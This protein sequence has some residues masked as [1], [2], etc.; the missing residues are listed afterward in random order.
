MLATGVILLPPVLLI[1]K[2][3]TIRNKM[4]IQEITSQ[5][6]KWLVDNGYKVN[7]NNIITKGGRQILPDGLSTFVMTTIQDVNLVAALSNYDIT[8]IYTQITSIFSNSVEKLGI[9]SEKIEILNILK[10]IP[11]RTPILPI[12]LKNFFKDSAVYCLDE[13]GTMITLRRHGTIGNQWAIVNDLK[14]GIK[15][16]PEDKLKTFKKI[17]TNTYQKPMQG[18]T[19]IVYNSDGSEYGKCEWPKLIDIA[20]LRAGKYCKLHPNNKLPSDDY[21]KNIRTARTLSKDVDPT[22][23]PSYSVTCDSIGN[24]NVIYDLW[25]SD[26]ELAVDMPKTLTNDPN[27]PA[28]CYVDINTFKKAETPEFDGF[29]TS[30][31][32][33]VREVFMA[34][35]YATVFEPCHHSLVVWMHGEGSNGKSEFFSAI[36]EY[37]GGTLVGSMSTK[38]LS[39]EFGMEGLIGKRIIIWGDCQNGN[40]LSTNEVHGITGGDSISVNRKNKPIISYKFKSLLFIGAN[41]SPDIKLNAINETRRVLYVPMSDPSLEVMQ[42]YCETNIDGTIKRHSTGQPMFKS[43]DLRGKLVIEM[44]A[45]MG[46][47]KEM[48]HKYCK[49]P[50]NQI[51]VPPEAFELMTKQ[52]EGGQNLVFN[53]FMLTQFTVTGNPKDTISAIDVNSAY[54]EHVHGVQASKKLTQFNFELSDLKRYILTTHK[55]DVE[56]T[57]ISVGNQKLRVYTGLKRGVNIIKNDNE[58]TTFGGD[59]DD[60]L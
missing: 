21:I 60:F 52:C 18:Q 23:I 31:A 58:I 17:H 29:L 30:I 16:L 59:S 20:V 24:G 54:L 12:D 53:D 33:E 38:T 51:T 39:G 40:A 26:Q 32:P 36:N 2:D 13:H 44:P 48:F 5:I 43:Y 46:K 15:L 41:K 25:S 9:S 4:T 50:Y 55:N 22:I 11:D 14:S 35:I 3:D 27:I 19:F 47:C 28:F 49:A 8:N 37:F 45:I 57:R 6:Y 10:F 34:C 1:F 7:R 42:K 56:F